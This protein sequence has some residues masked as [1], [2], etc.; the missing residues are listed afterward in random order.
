[1]TAMARIGAFVERWRV[2]F[3]YLYLEA[4]TLS[5]HLA[6]LAFALRSLPP[7]PPHDPPPL[8]LVGDRRSANFLGLFRLGRQV[9]PLR[10]R[11]IRGA[12]ELA[13]CLA[14]LEARRWE[15]TLVIA[16]DVFVRYHDQI[17]A[18]PAAR[19]RLVA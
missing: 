14:E 11:Q 6:Q 1:M 4:D 18:S 12:E 17:A 19:G 5:D 16:G 8:V 15:G 7:A 9:P 2:R 13:D 10:V 3:K